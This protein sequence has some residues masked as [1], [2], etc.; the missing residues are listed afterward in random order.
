MA[1]CKLCGQDKKLIKAHIIPEPFYQLLY[2]D[3]HRIAEI[4]FKDWAVVD[5]KYRSKGIYDSTILCHDCDGGI[6]GSK[7]D[8]YAASVFFGSHKNDWRIKRFFD[9]KDPR[10]KWLEA[11]ADGS[12]IKLFMLS[13]LWRAHVSSFSNFANVDL[14]PLHGQRIKDMLI[15]CDAGSVEEYPVLLMNYTSDSEKG[16]AF[17]SGIK[18]GRTVNGGIFYSCVMAGIVSIWYI[19]PGSEPSNLKNFF[20]FDQT[21]IKVLDTPT[22]GWDFVAN[23]TNNP[24]FR[25][26]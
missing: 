25:N 4:S 11:T 18:K 1:I 20:L 2:D 24:M 23:V 17:M 26:L 8:D 19:S 7:Y 16:R 13:I 9:E 3:K 5:E 14:G 6:I 21:K 10:V 22:Q 15:N 12:R